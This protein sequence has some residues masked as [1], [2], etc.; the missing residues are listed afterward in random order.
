MPVSFCFEPAID[1][2]D[3]VRR[4]FCNCREVFEGRA[5]C[6]VAPRSGGSA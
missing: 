3:G 4:T 5:Y 6:S 1:F 2:E